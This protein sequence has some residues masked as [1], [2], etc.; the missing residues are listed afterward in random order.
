MRLLTVAG[1]L[2]FPGLGFVLGRPGMAPFFA[3]PALMLVPSL[4]GYGGPKPPGSDSSSEEGGGGGGGRR[5][6]TPPRGPWGGTPLPDAEQSRVRLRDHGS[7][8]R[9][10]RPHRRAP[11]EHPGRPGRRRVTPLV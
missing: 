3:L 10:A 2:L 7:P 5:R 6:P 9:L 1:L 8:R 4:M 11:A